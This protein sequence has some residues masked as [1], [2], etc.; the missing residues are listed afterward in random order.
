MEEFILE[1]DSK[2]L[3]YLF[4]FEIKICFEFARNKKITL[5]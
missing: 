3:I 1:M 5:I 2:M 4:L